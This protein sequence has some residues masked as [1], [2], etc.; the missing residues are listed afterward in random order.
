MLKIKKDIFKKFI[1]FINEMSKEDISQQY[2]GIP[3]SPLCLQH[4]SINA[5][6]RQEKKRNR[7]DGDSVKERKMKDQRE[8]KWG[9]ESE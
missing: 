3:S 5:P 6:L 7:A 9:R 2:W 8:K 1:H 4:I